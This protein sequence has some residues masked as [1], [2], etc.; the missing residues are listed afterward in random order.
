M[1]RQPIFKKINALNEAGQNDLVELFSRAM[2][3]YVIKRYLVKFHRQGSNLL[4]SF[5]NKNVD[6][7]WDG[8]GGWAGSKRYSLDIR[9]LPNGMDSS[10]FRASGCMHYLNKDEAYNDAIN[11]LKEKKQKLN[12]AIVDLQYALHSVE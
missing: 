6:V 10:K 4:V 1:R 9:H 11:L 5:Y 2:E 7:I 12:K 8:W 3:G